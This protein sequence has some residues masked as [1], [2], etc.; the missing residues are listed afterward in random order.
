[1]SRTLIRPMAQRFDAQATGAVKALTV[2]A[3]IIAIFNLGTW[4]QRTHT[5]LVQYCSSDTEACWEEIDFT[6]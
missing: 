2:I 5:E 4:Y 1:M 6:N 3:F